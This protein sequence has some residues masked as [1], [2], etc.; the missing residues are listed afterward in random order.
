MLVK[1]L[2]SGCSNCAALERA[3][4][5]AL[6]RLG[7]SAD[8]EK[9]TDYAAIAGYG[10]MSTPALVV[11][12]QVVLAGRVPTTDQLAELLSAHAPG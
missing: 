10:V 3:T 2:G 8:V 4:R 6:A 1:I 7:L 12:E 11:G 5:N 9:V